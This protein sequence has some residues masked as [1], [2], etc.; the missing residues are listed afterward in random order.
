M[1]NHAAT[2]HAGLD[3]GQTVPSTSQGGAPLS[4]GNVNFPQHQ[5]PYASQSS[6][7]PEFCNLI[8]SHSQLPFDGQVDST[9]QTGSHPPNG[10][11]DLSCMET[12][13]PS[14]VGHLP[15]SDLVFDH[16]SAG[17]PFSSSSSQSPVLPQVLLAP[18]SLNTR[19]YFAHALPS[20]SS[21]P[22]ASL[23]P[24][25]ASSHMCLSAI[26]PALFTPSA[27]FARFLQPSEA[28]D[29]PELNDRDYL[30]CEFLQSDARPL[31]FSLSAAV[32][33][34]RATK[35]SLYSRVQN[36]QCFAVKQSTYY[37]LSISPSMS[38]AE[39]DALSKYKGYLTISVFSDNSKGPPVR[40][41]Y[42]IWSSISERELSR[43]QE[44]DYTGYVATGG[45]V[46]KLPICY[47]FPFK[48]RLGFEVSMTV[49]QRRFAPIGVVVGIDS[50]SLF[51]VDS[52]PLPQEPIAVP[53]R[54]SDAV[55]FALDS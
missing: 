29:I 45:M 7:T 25:L 53:P 37:D 12:H 55:W 36:Q 4:L 44:L 52:C 42:L 9:Y 28:L 1:N 10:S 51:N 41:E 5:L 33:G 30:P 43:L 6:P 31:N 20:T 54:F 49:E 38:D 3:S 16:S 50:D 13:F 46:R 27:T 2:L 40:I 32:K 35:S 22:Q 48:I 21:P 39:I 18:P 19:G 8:F 26:E 11:G 24:P 15:T 34:K 14:S 23:M 47:S 17:A